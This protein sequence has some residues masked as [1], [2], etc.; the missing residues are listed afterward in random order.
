MVV[1][2]AWMAMATLLAFAALPACATSNVGTT[3]AS[4]SGTGAGGGDGGSGGGA[5]TVTGATGTGGNGIVCGDGDIATSE[6]CDDGNTDDGDG[7]SAACEFEKGWDCSGTK[8]TVCIEKCSDGL[9]VGKE[10]CDDGNTTKG[11]GCSDT[12][13][14]DNGY[15]CEGAPSQCGTVCG[16]GILAGKEECDDQNA[17]TADG[18]SDLCKVEK[19]WTCVGQPSTCMTSCGDGILAGAEA[20]D[21]HNFLPGDG[22]D[23]ACLVEQFWTCTGEPSTCMT[24]C[25]D[26]NVVGT[27]VCDDQNTAN[28]DGCNDICKPEPGYTCSGMP[29]KC[30]PTCGDGVLVAGAEVCDDGNLVNGDGC[31]A[32]CKK[33]PG[34]TC[35]G[36]TPTKCVTI[37]G[38]GYAAGL[39]TCDV[40]APKPNDGCDDN[41]HA[42]HG[43]VCNNFP[44]VC[45]TVCGDGVVG[46]TE[47]CDSGGVGPGCSASCIVLPGYTCSGEPSFCVTT[48]G[49]GVQAGKET[50]DD[51]NLINGDCCSNVCGAE[52]GCEVE[53][54]NGIPTANDFSALAISTTV[55]GTIK[56]AGDLDYYLVTIPAG[57]TAVLNVATL[58]GFN[59]SCVNLTQDSYLTVYDVNGVSLGTDDNSGPGSCA[60]LQVVGLAGGDYFVEVKS[61]SNSQFS[62]ALQVQ[63]QVVVCGNGTKEPGEQC[64]DGNAASGDGCSA[65]C[66]FEVATEIEPN[67]TPAQALANPLFPVN[68]LWAGAITP[69]GDN[70]YYRIHLNTT[71]DLRIETFDGNGPGTCATIDTVI[72][73]YGPNGTTQLATDDQGGINS[74]SLID[75]NVAATFPGARHLAPGDYYVRVQSYLNSGVIGAYDVVVTYNAV[76]GNGVL[77]GAEQCDGGANCSANCDILPTC[78]D[79][80]ISVGESCE[81]GNTVS[82][83][84][85]SATCQQEAGYSC[86]TA[87][88]NVCT[89]IISC[90]LPAQLFV[91]TAT[92][93]PTAIIDNVTITNTI[94]VPTAGTV[95]QAVMQL[96]IT[97]TY[98]ADVDISLKSPA[99]AAGID[100]SSDNGS[101]SDNYTNTIFS[102]NCTTP[103]ASGVAPFNGCYKPEAPLSSFIGQPAAGNWVL[104]VGDDLIVYTG[105]LN[106]WKL[107][108]CVQ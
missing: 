59:S 84:G 28:N 72:Y 104:G 30:V 2:K 26:G 52:A 46:G 76:C 65:T 4:S 102:D 93:L 34:F 80:F 99:S 97:H 13:T 57:Q 68:Q 36:S 19:G 89:A 35:T 44:S 27:E 6:V 74:C 21:D 40:G 25:G 86:T 79:N 24:P 87:L 103:V 78:G 81:D 64:D 42:E 47:A 82:G 92:G 12:C 32:V 48:C 62:Y 53:A 94:T 98:D 69:S 49:D 71:S 43:Y 75:S 16:D 88:P 73:L 107:T 54:N 66:T 14:V 15:T 58:D 95:V 8:V 90:P 17:S 23:D 70:D 33:E 20:C 7:C 96:D 67:N 22:C 55:K 56:P 3:A 77:E 91:Y 5:S 31:N 51:G 18:C 11:D 29:S 106:S 10:K 39:E 1:K 85:C 37:C 45:Q 50:C 101:S 60:Q 105:T 41:C 100:I 61:G 63:V 108:L 9:V 83:D 38:D